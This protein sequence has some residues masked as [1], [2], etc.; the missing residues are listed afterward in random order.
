MKIGNT[1]GQNFKI[2]IFGNSHDNEMILE[3]FG[4]PKGISVD[5]D[6]INNDLLRRRPKYTFDTPR[7]EQDEYNIVEGVE[8]DKTTGAKIIVTV[9]NK[10]FENSSYKKYEDIFRP[11]HADFTW[12][13][14]YGEALPH[15]GGIAS[16]RE[17]VLRVIAGAFA[18]M[19][20]NEYSNQIKFNSW[21]YSIGDLIQEKFSPELPKNFIDC[22]SEI[23]KD[24]DS[25]GGKV[26]CII[27]DL[28]AG[29]GTPPFDK[30]QANLAYAMMTIPAVKAFEIGR[31]VEASQM[32]GSEHNDPY[33]FNEID[34]KIKPI[35]NDAGGILGGITS[36][37]DIIMTVSFKPIP[38]INKVQN[39]VNKQGEKV[40]LQITGSHDVCA[41]V[42]GAVVVEA[43]AA[44]VLADMIIS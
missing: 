30:F 22:L 5:Y 39:T 6:L 24:G 32:K 40:K 10:C 15:G 34:G 17:T 11:S 37:E 29:F 12:E 2:K 43:M 27:K 41:A 23:R 26:R 25:I 38:S 3:I 20:L 8:N 14:K 1:F 28:S 44:I 42:R 19:F 33:C 9:K 13:L 7:Q 35:K 16:A 31:G 21:T 4:M 36:G 18:K